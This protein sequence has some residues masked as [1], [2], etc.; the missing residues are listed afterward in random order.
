MQL[1]IIEEAIKYI[2]KLH[3]TLMTRLHPN[4]SKYKPRSVHV[5]MQCRY[6]YSLQPVLTLLP[7]SYANSAATKK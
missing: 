7:T 4:L 3:S 5:L 2:D 1:A 6:M